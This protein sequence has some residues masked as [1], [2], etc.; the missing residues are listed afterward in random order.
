M[1]RLYEQ[2]PRPLGQSGIASRL[3]ARHLMTWPQAFP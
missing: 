2:D 3:A 1:Q